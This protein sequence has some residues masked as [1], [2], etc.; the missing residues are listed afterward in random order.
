MTVDFGYWL[1]QWHH[2]CAF[3]KFNCVSPSANAV[4]SKA[5]K[6]A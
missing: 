4:A 5:L 2:N 3:K 1:H 6:K